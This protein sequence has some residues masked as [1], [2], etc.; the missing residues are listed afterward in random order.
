MRQLGDS[1][2]RSASSGAPM[3]GSFKG[4]LLIFCMIAAGVSV[5]GLLRGFKLGETLVA[6][7]MLAAVVLAGAWLAKRTDA[8]LKGK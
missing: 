6:A 4:S 8:R 2:R 3:I 5:F 7:A 1:T